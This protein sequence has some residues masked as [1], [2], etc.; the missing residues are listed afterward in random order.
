M[1]VEPIDLTQQ[2]EVPES[3]TPDWYAPKPRDKK[4]YLQAKQV[5]C[6]WPKCS[7]DKNRVLDSIKTL[8]VIQAVVAH[9]LHKDGTDHLH[10]Y[11]CLINQNNV[12]GY[13]WLDK[14][15]DSHHGNYQSVRNKMHVLRYITKDKDYCFFGPDPVVFVQN[16][17]KHEAA[18]QVAL[19]MVTKMR[20]DPSC[21]LVML[22]DIDPV[23]LLR[24]KRKAEEYLAFQQ[25]KRARLEVKPWPTLDITGLTGPTLRIAKW[26]IKNIKQE[27]A[28]K[29]KQL[30]IYGPPGK[31]KTH[32]VNRLKEY[33]AVYVIP[34]TPFV[35]GYS[36]TEYDLVLC[37]EFKAHFTIQFLNEF[38]QGSMMHLNQKGGGTVKTKN[39]PMIF[40]SNFCLEECYRKSS[41]VAV[42]A[43]KCRFKIVVVG[44]YDERIDVPFGE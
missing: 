28:F 32:L 30:Y 43:L 35:D 6:T 44:E 4:F 1:Q 26:L 7:V 40:L 31:G 36:D 39:L 23:W 42:D 25:M 9:E 29:Q 2:D 21:T 15:A 20:E 27:R 16:R 17:E 34:K 19:E 8:G 38:L 18:S 41:P 14:L 10:A 5:Y 33:L 13:E 22:D 12:R 37:D 24:N 11:F 3:S